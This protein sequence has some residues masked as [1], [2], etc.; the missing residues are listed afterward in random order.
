MTKDQENRKIAAAALHRFYARHRPKPQLSEKRVLE[1]L[2]AYKGSKLKLQ[3][4]TR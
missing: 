1:V 3:L 2:N 4:M